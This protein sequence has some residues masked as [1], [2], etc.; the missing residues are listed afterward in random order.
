MPAGDF[1]FISSPLSPRPSQAIICEIPPPMRLAWHPYLEPTLV[2]SDLSRP[3]THDAFGHRLH[4]AFA[5]LF[6]F[7]LPWPT[8]I[9]QFAGI[10]LMVFFVL[11]TPHIW[12]T[13]GSLAMQP[14]L[15]AIGLFVAWQA[16]TLLWSGDSRQGLRELSSNRWVWTLWLLWP[17]MMHRNLLIGALAAGFLCGNMAQV[18]HAVGLQTGT[19]W[20]IWPRLPDRNSGWWDPV[21]GGTMLVGALGL[22]LPVAAMG[23][24]K[25]RVVAC[26]GAAIT[27]LGI[28]AT[29][30]RGAWIAAIAL[31]ALILCTA[32]VRQVLLSRRS[33]GRSRAWG[34]SPALAL[35]VLVF[36][37]G[38]AGWIFVGDSMLRR[39]DEARS[40]VT[41]VSAGDYETYTGAR[42]LMAEWAATAAVEHPM[43]VGAGGYATWTQE[44]LRLRGRD[45]LI[46]HVHSHAH[47][48]FLH[49]A[50]TLG[51]V[52]LAFALLIVGLALVGAFGHLGPAGLGSYAAGPG[53]ALLGLLLVSPFDVVHM[54]SQTSALLGTLCALCL[55]SRPKLP[56]KSP[57]VPAD[58]SP[59]RVPSTIATE[60]NP[61]QAEGKAI[62]PEPAPV[63]KSRSTA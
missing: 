53:F 23:R 24:G 45:H 61:H 17:V 10:P 49:I 1:P 62:C 7:L 32:V 25:W 19:Q 40:E 50:A 11:R 63:A 3:I 29:G 33:A 26:A 35:V 21:V 55:I 20:L 57:S 38:I 36:S 52:G 37:A 54:N 43:G 22:H 56:T 60:T 9:V 12:R 16:T 28:F 51:I 4:L 5:M 34:L 30:T 15:L 46:P 58:V 13:W 18:L 59:A 6:C 42:I 47:N 2:Q 48:A 8:S 27:L 41:R 44:Q 39:I 14:L 31:I